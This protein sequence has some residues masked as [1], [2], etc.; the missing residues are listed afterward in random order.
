MIRLCRDSEAEAIYSIINDAAEAY[1]GIIPQDRWQ[2][3]YMSKEELQEEMNADVT[4]WGYEED[5]ELLGV[6][7]IQPVQDVTLIRHAYVR[8]AHQGQGIGGM[9]L[10]RLGDPLLC[11][12][13]L[14]ITL[15][16]REGPLA[17]QLLV[18]PR[19]SD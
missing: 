5:G 11:E 10:C 9:L 18:Y 19:A 17:A 4:F 8:P 6:M 15:P 12:A 13:R 2:E 16:G 1:K 3:P 7:G 14:S